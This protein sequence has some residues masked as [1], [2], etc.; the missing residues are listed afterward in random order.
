M[1]IKMV[2][3]KSSTTGLLK[4]LDVKFFKNMT[5]AETVRRNTIWLFQM[6]TI[7]LKTTRNCLPLWRNC[8]NDNSPELKRSDSLSLYM[9]TSTRMSTFH[10]TNLLSINL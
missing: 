2:N 1:S 9:L 6:M 5:K 10:L 3:Q 8:S 7:S 4:N